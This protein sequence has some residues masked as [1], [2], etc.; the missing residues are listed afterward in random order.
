MYLS[1]LL[2]YKLLEGGEY[3][4]FNF[5][6]LSGLSIMLWHSR[7]SRN[8]NS[9]NERAVLL[10]LFCSYSFSLS[11]SPFCTV[12]ISLWVFSTSVYGKSRASKII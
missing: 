2:D 5:I 12:Q 8:I 3:I 10:R 1:L 11:T 7:C 9:L 4:Y 6:S